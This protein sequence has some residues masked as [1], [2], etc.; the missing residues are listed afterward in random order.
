MTS[1]QKAH[2]E[3]FWKLETLGIK[4]LMQ[5]NDDDKALQRSN[6]MIHFED[7]HYQATWPWNEESPSL[8]T[9]M[10]W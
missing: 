2:L 6:V 7:R 3:P 1:N 9:I 10:S 8:P 4:K 5:E